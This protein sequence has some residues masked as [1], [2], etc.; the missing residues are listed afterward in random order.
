MPILIYTLGILAL[1]AILLFFSYLD[2]VYRELGRVSTGRTHAHLELFEGE[3]EPRSIWI[4]N[5]PLLPSVSLL[6][7]GWLWWQLLPP[8]L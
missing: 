5:A 4:V 8:E 1:T 6:A 3:V 7:Y 2:R